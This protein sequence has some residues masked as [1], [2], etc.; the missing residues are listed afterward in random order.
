MRSW[1]QADK[2]LKVIKY[3]KDLNFE[4]FPL[5]KQLYYQRRIA[6]LEYWFNSDVMPIG[7]ELRSRIGRYSQY[8]RSKTRTRIL[9][10][11]P[12]YS[13]SN[14]ERMMTMVISKVLQRQM[15]WL[16]DITNTEPSV[17]DPLIQEISIKDG[18]F[19]AYTGVRFGRNDTFPDGMIKLK[20]T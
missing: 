17:S 3:C 11:V 1:K 4:T 19:I 14:I 8:T 15:T 5:V 20:C 2:S 12:D 7:P 6:P 18:E 10:T 9:S 13:K 16:L